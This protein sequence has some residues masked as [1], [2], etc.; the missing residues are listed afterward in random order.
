MI[1][2]HVQ[3]VSFRYSAQRQARSF[4][5]DGWVRNAPDGSVEVVVE[6]EPEAVRLFVNW[7]H[8]GPPGATVD[9]IDTE[10][11]APRGEQGFRILR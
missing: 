1:T 2:G 5:L 11:E 9:S 8:S 3:G 10:E 7:A 6:G 4:G